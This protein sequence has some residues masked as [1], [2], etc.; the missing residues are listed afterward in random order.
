LSQSG[1]LAQFVQPPPDGKAFLPPAEKRC[2]RL[3]GTAE[4][5]RNLDQH[6]GKAAGQLKTK[7]DPKILFIGGEYQVW[8]PGLVAMTF[9][10]SRFCHT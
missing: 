5:T 9:D 7:A 1:V 10:A 4:E 8:V 3:S 2:T 6:G